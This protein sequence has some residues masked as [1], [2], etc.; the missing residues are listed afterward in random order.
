MSFEI[1]AEGV[2]VQ[3]LLAEVQRRVE[4]RRGVLYTEE[5]LR[6]IAER[7]LEG[8]LQPHEVRADLLEE[9]RRRDSAWNYSFDAE[10]LY[11][12]SHGPAGRIIEAARRLLRPVQKLFWNPNPMISALSRQ[13]DLNRFSVHLL[14]N[15]VLELTRLHLEV[16]E[17]QSRNLELEGRLSALARREKTLEGMVAYREE[18]GAGERQG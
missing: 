13:A 5:E 3:R 4:E 11:R 12:S 7:P 1:K 2:D 15:L 6:T 18:G 9:F 17:L 16:R 10:S 8:V 14:H